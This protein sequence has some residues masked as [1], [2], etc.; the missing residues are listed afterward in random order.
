MHQ[1][2]KGSFEVKLAPQAL[3]EVARDAKLGRMSIDKIFSGDLNAVSK[4]EMLSAMGEVKGSAGYVAL[5]RVNGA[6]LGRKG[7]FVLQ[8]F[9]M[10]NR[11]TPTL[12]VNV[13]ADSGTE[14]LEGLSGTLQIDIRDGQHFYQFDFEL[15]AAAQ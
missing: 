11:G 13:V 12:M 9:G 4:G 3:S 10:M 8:H 14:Q 5:E 6:L 15:P 2:A 1:T 7:S